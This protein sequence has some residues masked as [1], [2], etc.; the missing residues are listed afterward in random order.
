MME[1]MHASETSVAARV[2]RY[3]ISGD[4]IL[5]SHCRKHLKSHNVMKQLSSIY[6]YCSDNILLL[7]DVCFCFLKKSKDGATA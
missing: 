1:A 5:H 3:H 7:G 6:A 2:T 4:G